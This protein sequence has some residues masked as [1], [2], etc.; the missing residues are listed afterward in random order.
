M[1]D[2]RFGTFTCDNT[3]VPYAGIVNC[4]LE[5]NVTYGDIAYGQPLDFNA[6]VKFTTPW[7]QKYTNWSYTVSVPVLRNPLLVADIVAENCTQPS[8][9]TGQEGRNHWSIVCFFMP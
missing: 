3:T 5:Y 2:G 8:P 6:F 9:T 7:M 4:S 1:Y